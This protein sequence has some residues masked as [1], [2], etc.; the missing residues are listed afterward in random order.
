MSKQPQWPPQWQPQ[1]QPNGQNWHG[2]QRGVGTAEWIGLVGAILLLLAAT[3]AALSAGGGGVGA[4]TAEQMVC[5]VQGWGGGASCGGDGPNADSD[6][7]PVA[8]APADAA[9]GGESVG[10]K[11]NDADDSDSGS[12]SGNDSGGGWWNPIDGLIDLGEGILIDGLWA[13]ITGT[14]TMIGDGIVAT[15]GIGHALDW[16]GVADR[17]AV[18]QKYEDLWAHVQERGFWGTAY[19]L[20][21]RE[22]VEIWRDGEPLRAIG[23][24]VYNVGMVFVPGDEVGKIS[25]VTKLERV[26]P[27]GT[28]RIIT[29]VEDA[30]PDEVAQ[31]IA[32]V[33][34]MPSGR[35]DELRRVI[36]NMSDADLEELRRLLRDKTPEELAEM[37]LD[38]DDL[39]RVGLCSFSAN[40]PVSTPDGLRAISTLAVGDWVLAYD[41]QTGR[42]GY[43]PIE[44]TWVH[45]DPT[46][47]Y[48][49]IDGTEIETTPGHPFYVEGK[50]VLARELWL[51]APVAAAD[52]STGTVEA[53]ASV[54]RPQAMYNLTVAEAHTYFV[55]DGQ[56]LVHNAGDCPIDPDGV[57]TRRAQ[58][59]IGP[60]GTFRDPALE[61]DYQRYVERKQRAG[62]APRDRADW[63]VQSDYWT[64]DSPIARGND[65]NDTANQNYRYS[66][67][68]LENGK[69]LD[70][71]DPSTGEIVSRKA[72]DFDVVQENTYRSYLREIKDKY[73]EG[74]EI[75]SNKYPELDGQPLSGDYVLEVPSSNLNATNRAEFERIAAEEGIRIR[76]V[77]EA[78]GEIIETTPPIND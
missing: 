76:Y 5:L 37:G 15:P 50:W 20:T 56:W 42:T 61:A 53:L 2:D 43:H 34:D 62:Q 13:D 31:L 54:E 48:V 41:E 78:T 6:T 72:T 23:I 10:N 68:H 29:L 22:P 26:L 46:V 3:G 36:D 75:R 27:D 51:G 14:L 32:R 38:I 69:R 60:D 44:A 11:S 65:F 73:A 45:V 58:E 25:K 7:Q 59:L 8:N 1:W 33:D 18:L 40:T 17:D 28:T 49:T 67:V 47:T 30:L 55:G 16:L 39:Q 64:N 70:A 19:D 35:V 63:K 57:L 74:T 21:L 52:G 4:T 77:D 9:T 12:G 66:E 24:G 71:Y